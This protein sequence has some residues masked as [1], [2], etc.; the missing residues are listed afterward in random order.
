[1]AQ[2][3]RVTPASEIVVS[4]ARGSFM[5]N[6]GCLHRGTEIV[7]PFNGKRWIIC[8]LSFRDRRVPQWADGRYTVLFFHDEAVALAAGQRPCAECR[9]P[10]FNAF[11]SAWTDA[12]GPIRSVDELD[13][14][15][16]LERLAGR[17]QR[18][19]EAEWA[20]LPDGTFVLVAGQPAL[21]LGSTLRPWSTS[22]YG[23]P[24]GRP[25]GGTATLLTPPSTVEVLRRGYEPVLSL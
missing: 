1:M 25:S 14:Q 10:R 24:M 12:F 22:G 18:R 17:A 7:R 20:S 9:R 6:R 16:H 11:R 2:R 19:H 8:D 3:N 4:S 21:V 5:G 23:P 13:A 15:L